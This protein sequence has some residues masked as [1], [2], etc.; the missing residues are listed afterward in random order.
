MPED[1]QARHCVMN[2]LDESC[3]ESLHSGYSRPSLTL[4]A[5]KDETRPPK[6]LAGQTARNSGHHVE[7]FLLRHRTD[8]TA[9]HSAGRPTTLTSPVARTLYLRGGDS[10]V[11]DFDSIGRNAGIDHGGLYRL[12]DCNEC[13]YPVPILEADLFGRERDT[14]RN[15]ETCFS[16]S[17]ERQPRDRVRARIV[18]VHDSRVPLRS[19]GTQLTRGAD[20]P[21]AAERQAIC[22]KTG[23]FCAPDQRG[24]G[25][26]YNECSIPE[27]AKSGGEQKYLTLAA[28]P[29]APGVDVKNP[30]KLH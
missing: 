2:L 23:V 18:C 17:E 1:I 6:N 25:R 29:A 15:N 21:F 8:D 7:P 13:I 9:D 19:D 10:R 28:A 24:T 5:K 11:D 20:I 26:C 22:G 4:S 27:I 30:G 16:L 14:T 12:R 3:V